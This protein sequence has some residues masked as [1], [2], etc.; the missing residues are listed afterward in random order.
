MTV[1]APCDAASHLHLTKCAYLPCSTS[2]RRTG[3]EINLLSFLFLLLLLFFFKRSSYTST[4]R[5]HALV[6]FSERQDSLGG[7]RWR[8][9]HYCWEA[10]GRH[11]HDH[12]TPSKLWSQSFCR[13][14]CFFF[15]FFF[16]SLTPTLRLLITPLWVQ[17]ACVADLKKKK[18]EEEEEKEE[19][20]E[21]HFCLS[22][23]WFM[24]EG[25]REAESAEYV[26]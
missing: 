5:S 25:G 9:S 22:F 19:E 10:A 23:A 12:L 2:F 7:R 14:K 26:I 11:L 21:D 18:E 13:R 24:F 20:E 17:S 4:P 1:P 15:F 3:G 8:G 16:F 6:F